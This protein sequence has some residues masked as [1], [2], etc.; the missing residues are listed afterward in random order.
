M[1]RAVLEE[2]GPHRQGSGQTHGREQK[3]ERVLLEPDVAVSAPSERLVPGMMHPGAG[4]ASSRTFPMAVV[5]A[6]SALGF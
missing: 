5:L 2:W 3:E 4:R 1:I 6:D